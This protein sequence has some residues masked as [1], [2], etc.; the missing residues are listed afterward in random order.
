VGDGILSSKQLKL[1]PVMEA[2]T[3]ESARH[4]KQNVNGSPPCFWVATSL[5]RV[6]DSLFPRFISLFRGVGNFAPSH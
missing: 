3:S 5:I 6:F 4:R 2:D 1:A